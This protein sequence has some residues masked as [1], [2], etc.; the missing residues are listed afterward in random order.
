MKNG[1]EGM[2]LVEALSLAGGAEVIIRAH[3]ALEA[4]PSHL[5]LASITGHTR[6]NHGRGMGMWARRWRGSQRRWSLKPRV[7][8]SMVA[9]VVW[10]WGRGKGEPWD[11]MRG[12]ITLVLLFF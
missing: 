5:S 9:H 2:L 12:E 8:V 1:Q 6:V 11:P 3:G 4:S 7:M 10:S